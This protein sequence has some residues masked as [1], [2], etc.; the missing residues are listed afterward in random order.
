MEETS[1]FKLD[2]SDSLAAAPQDG[3]KAK[4]KDKVV[5]EKGQVA[6]ARA[7]ADLEAA[8]S[9]QEEATDGKAAAAALDQAAA[10]ASDPVVQEGRPAQDIQESLEA[11]VA[12]MVL[13][14]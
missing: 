10:A 13:E 3:Q 5:Q 6:Q 14:G 9:A 8:A 11:K 2:T 12:Q 4:A 7:S 1:E